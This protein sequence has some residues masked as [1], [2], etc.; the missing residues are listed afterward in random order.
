MNK[1]GYTGCFCLVLAVFLALGCLL[2]GCD[3]YPTGRSVTHKDLTLILPGDFLDLSGEETARDAE[4]LYGRY[5]LVFKGLAE[6]KESLQEMTLETYTS[7][8][9][10][11]NRLT[12]SPAAFGDG[13]LF[14]YEAKI[15]DT[16]YSYTVATYETP[17]NFWILQFYCPKD[18]LAENQPEIDIILQ[19]IQPE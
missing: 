1:K 11:G 18:K 17:A 7:Y 6:S 15:G 5:T 3:D 10:S 19:G 8:V 2:T 12:C 16:V 9:I 4:F 14:T 13:Y